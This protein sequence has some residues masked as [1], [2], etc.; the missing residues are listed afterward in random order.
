MAQ[1][2]CDTTRNLAR[3]RSRT[4]ATGDRRLR[5][6][7]RTGS[8]RRRPQLRRGRSPRAGRCHKRCQGRRPGAAHD[9]HAHAPLRRHPHWRARR[10]GAATD[11]RHRR[12]CAGP[13]CHVA[14]GRHRS[15][16][17]PMAGPR[18]R[19]HRHTQSGADPRQRA[20]AARP[21]AG[22]T[23]AGSPPCRAWRRTTKSRRRR[24]PPDP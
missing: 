9:V 21:R 13:G 7:A 18:L 17:A 1:V 5:G 14:R 23:Q 22:C 20:D 3:P 10:P 19:R 2:V 4:H 12:L 24:S 6:A 8:E 16:G 11:R 15:R